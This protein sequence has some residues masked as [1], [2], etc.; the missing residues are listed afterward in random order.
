M[1][2]RDRVMKAGAMYWKW[3]SVVCA[4]LTSLAL[5]ETG[6]PA[7]PGAEGFGANTPGGRGGRVLFVVNL[8]DYEPST[9]EPVPGSLRAACETDGPRIVVFH[10][11][12]TIALKAPL[13][14]N[15]PYITIAG[16]SA[17][18]G[19]VCLRRHETV[20]RTHDVIVRYMRFRPG[21]EM[22]PEYRKK[23]KNFAPDALLFSSGSRNAIVDHCSTSWAIDEVLSIS[24]EGITNVTVQWCMITE[25]LNDSCHTKGKHGYGSLLRCNGNVTFH[26]NLYAHHNSRTP[27]PGTYGEG[28]IMLDF[29]NNVIYN[30]IHGGYS[31]K[32]P[33]KVNYINNYV[34]RGPDTVSDYAFLVGGEAT[35]LYVKGNRMVGY[36]RPIKNDWDVIAGAE[37][38][39]R[40]KVPFPA[41]PV[42]T[43]DADAVYGKV[44]ASCGATLPLRD[45][46]DARII[47]E[48]R[49][50]KG[51]IID[52]Q[53]QVGGWPKLKQAPAPND[54]DHDGM[55]DDWESRHGLEP[56]DPS[57]NNKDSDGDGYTNIEEVIN[58]TDPHVKDT[59]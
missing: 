51:R 13:A 3:A 41:A 15:K 27:R 1:V 45:A 50:G 18:G 44:L 55:P 56:T 8:E 16:Q 25:S 37:D 33:A 4:C 6:I 22:G 24:N 59:H 57:D 11:A 52:S 32:D 26:H 2:H 20:I 23:G 14:I 12:G 31:A 7:F 19:G 42:T 40:H 48:I 49:T 29:R 10:V 43:D 35:Q 39:N 17:P 54:A 28:C 38:G 58:G 9:E 46:V 53:K 5:A 34:K 47:E 21:D 30:A 36:S